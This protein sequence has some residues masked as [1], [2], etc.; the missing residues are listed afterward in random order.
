MENID[1]LFL[2]DEYVTCLA[3]GIHPITKA[4]LPDDSVINDVKIVR[5]LYFVSEVLNDSI[6]KSEK[7]S[8]RKKPF[9]LSQHDLYRFK[10]SNGEITI[11]AIVRKLNDLKTDEN[12]AKLTTKPFTQWLLNCNLLQEVEE[13]GK[14]VKRPTDAGKSL[15]MSVRKII[16]DYGVFNAV[17]Y[18]SKAQQFLID[19]F[20][21]II[22]FDKAIHPIEY[23]SNEESKGSPYENSGQ[24]WSYDD[25]M[26]LIEM[27]NN[28]CS[29][30]EMSEAL[31]RS[32]GSVKSRLKKL[33]FIDQYYL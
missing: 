4:V 14:I 16:T 15:G 32:T 27:Y 33:G 20:M 2:A 9:N 21:S 13:K 8:G 23:K 25:E 31:Q 30:D 1:N 5:C 18:N 28:K 12:M 19:N 17:V 3:K 29:A 26:T 22:N 7:K 10:I 11:S 24:P 6:K